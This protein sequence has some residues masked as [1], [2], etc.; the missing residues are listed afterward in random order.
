VKILLGVED[1][2]GFNAS[3]K[4]G[5]DELGVS[6][7]LVDLS[8][9]RFAFTSDVGSSPLVSAARWARKRPTRTWG[10]K[11]GWKLI[12]VMARLPLFVA[13][14]WTHDV[15]VFGYRTSFFG[16]RDL[17]LL[18]LLG[19]KIVFIFHGSDARPPYLDGSVMAADAGRTIDDCIALSHRTKREIRTIER[20][21]DLVLS[22]P[23]YSHFHEKP[24]VF[25]SLLGS[26]LRPAGW[27]IANRRDS[28]TLRVVHAPSHPAAKGTPVIRETVRLLSERGVPIELVELSNVSNATV[29]EELAGCDFV[30][31]QI[32]SESPLSRL[33]I[34]AAFF[35]RPAIIAGHAAEEIAELFPPDM[36]PPVHYCHPD[37]L[38]SAV[39]RL[40][41][42]DRYR[43]ELGDRARAFARE[44]CSPM[45]VAAR[46]IELIEH[47]PPPGWTYDPRRLRYV[48]G[49]CL[50]EAR[51]RELV[52]DVVE[53]GGE[54][55]LEVSDKPEL[56][57]LL[58]ALAGRA[59]ATTQTPA[60]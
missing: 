37:D 26:P 58:L 38:E 49:A 4:T 9:H 24:I 8:P 55:A 1:V 45:I 18:K 35:G 50:T 46:L 33:S 48:G 31:D 11:V 42:D 16:L 19:K 30:I 27:P 29:L 54:T 34:E 53:R 41:S 22:Y 32:Y 14:V 43:Q 25:V 2:A 13:A 12:S 51:A 40:A 57:A 5:L 10:F 56:E 6:A 17:P 36:L 60:R 28:S 21:A 47:G 7:T 44:N 52:R 39:R 20:H 23:L 59:P 15:F 3:L